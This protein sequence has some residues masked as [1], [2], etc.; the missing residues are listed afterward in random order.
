MSRT[1][2]IRRARKSRTKKKIE[3]FFAREICNNV[4]VKRQEKK[5]K[6]QGFFGRKWGALYLL[7]L[8]VSHKISNDPSHPCATNLKTPTQTRA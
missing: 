3:S 1:G 6:G 4:K 2:S 7:V 8:R 5:R